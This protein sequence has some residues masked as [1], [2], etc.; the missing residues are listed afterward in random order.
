[1]GL[2]CFHDDHLPTNAIFIDEQNIMYPSMVTF[3]VVEHRQTKLS[4][5]T[6]IKHAAFH[7]TE[8]ITLFHKI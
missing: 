2:F 3:N 6:A 8:K 1:M 7:V 4:L 5:I